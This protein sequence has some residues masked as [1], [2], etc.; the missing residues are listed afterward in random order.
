MSARSEKTT[1]AFLRFSI[2]VALILIWP[3]ASS[4]TDGHF[5][6]GA[7]PV[8]EAMGG[9]DAGLCLDATGSIAWNPACTARFAGRRFELHGTIFIPWRSLSSTV[10]ANSFGPGMPGATLSGTTQSKTDTSF[11][12][13]FAFI[14]HPSGSSNAYHFGM[15]AVSGF[16][17]DYPANTDFSNPILTSQPPNGFGFGRVRSD[18][19]LVTLPVG[20]GR[21]ISER[22]SVGFSAVPSFSMLQVIPAPFSAPISGGSTMPYYLSARNHAPAFGG[23]FNLGLHYAFEKVNFGVS[24]RSPVWF[25]QFAW[26]SKDLT[27]T[28]HNLDFKMNLPQVISV[29]TGISPGKNTRIGVDV[30]WLNY[31]NTTGF[32]EVGYNDDD[33]VSGFGWKNIWTVGGGIQQKVSKSTKIMAGYNFSQNPVPD[34]YTFFNTPA[35]AIV[36]HHATAGFTQSVGTIDL[37]ATYYHAFKNSITGPWISPMGAMPGT[38]V[39]SSMSE[40]SV[41]F[42]FG[43]TF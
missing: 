2:F 17:V 1:A 27:G 29:G 20:L 18:Y 21:Q 30:R 33:A 12:P 26:K 38:S 28:S 7:G 11:M 13:G 22:L 19:M 40:N 15:L 41:T 35:P 43:K 24:Y 16:G 31:E 34:K 36:Q 5:L 42:G 4:A 3:V 39:T 10:D 14:Y 8:N 32:D 37:T 23:G 25:Q 9:A 6:H